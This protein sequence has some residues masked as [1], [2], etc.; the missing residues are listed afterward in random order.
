M[1]NDNYTAVPLNCMVPVYLED[2]K[3]SLAAVRASVTPGTILWFLSDMAHQLV[4]RAIKEME[5]I[6]GGKA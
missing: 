4:T 6:K 5:A 1:A 3:K 2:C